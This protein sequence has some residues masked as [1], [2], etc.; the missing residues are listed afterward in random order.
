[1]AE[2]DFWEGDAEYGTMEGAVWNPL[3]PGYESLFSVLRYATMA[4]L[5]FV[6]YSIYGY[7]NN[8]GKARKGMGMFGDESYLEGGGDSAIQSDADF[9]TYDVDNQDPNFTGPTATLSCIP[10]DCPCGRISA[11][12]AIDPSNGFLY[13]YGGETETDLLRGLSVY[14]SQNVRWSDVEVVSA[15][16]GQRSQAQMVV[17]EDLLVLYGGICNP[18]ERGDCVDPAMY[19]F[20]I[21]SKQWLQVDCASAA[22]EAANATSGDGENKGEV[23]G[24]GGE[25]SSALTVA[26]KLQPPARCGHSM[27]LWRNHTVVVFGGYSEDGY[28]GDTWSFDLMQLSDEQKEEKERKKAAGEDTGAKEDERVQWKQI[29]NAAQ[30]HTPPPRGHH[31]AVVM[32]DELIVIG[33]EDETGASALVAPGE[34]EILDIPSQ[35]WRVTATTGEGPE[36]CPGMHCH[37]MADT[38]KA[39]VISGENAGVFNKLY[40]L[41]LTPPSPTWSN[42]RVDWRGDWTMIPGIRTHHNR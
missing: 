21:E 9:Q 34:I 42:V 4:V 15:N 12:T 24:E 23:E 6:A 7:Y 30:S 35:M 37:Q 14:D 11:A 39:M 5:G 28:Y 33:G 25:Q 41:D 10:F 22:L 40:M 17:V 16:P 27:S 13:V 19:I 36:I 32:G 38:G 26:R 8:G 29:H 18:Q 1:M 20:H 2:E 31:G 3:G